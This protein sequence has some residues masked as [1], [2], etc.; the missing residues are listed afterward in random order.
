MDPY[1]VSLWYGP[2]PIFLKIL[3]SYPQ[4][5]ERGSATLHLSATIFPNLLHFKK[6]DSL[7]TCLDPLSNTV[8][9]PV[10]FDEVIIEVDQLLDHQESPVEAG[11]EA[12]RFQRLHR[13]ILR[14]NCIFRRSTVHREGCSSCPSIGRW[15]AQLV[16]LLLATAAL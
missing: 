12:S 3:D 1:S 14:T 9:F 4:K 5:N 7:I 16:A 11:E 15:V 8:S 10:A 13:L 2:G 6:K